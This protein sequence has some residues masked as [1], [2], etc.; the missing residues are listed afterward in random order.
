METNLS[1]FAGNIIIYLHG[2]KKIYKLFKLICRINKAGG[3]KVTKN[4]SCII[5]INNIQLEN[6]YF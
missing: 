1:L 5:Y 4:V 2:P 3:N 6:T